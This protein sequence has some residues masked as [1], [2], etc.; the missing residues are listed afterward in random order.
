[1]SFTFDIPPRVCPSCGHDNPPL[2]P[3]CPCGQALNA[4]PL[5]PTQGIPSG[6]GQ[7]PRS[8]SSM[9]STAAAVPGATPVAAMGQLSFLEHPKGERRRRGPL[10]AAAVLAI[11]A[12]AVLGSALLFGGPAARPAAIGGSASPS[13]PAATSPA[14][15]ESPGTPAG[16]P[17]PAASGPLDT[18]LSSARLDGGTWAVTFTVTASTLEAVQD[19][20]RLRRVYDA[21]YAC[22]RPPCDVKARAS[23]PDSPAKGSLALTFA[24]AAGAYTATE[25]AGSERCVLTSGRPLAGGYTVQVTTSLQVAASRQV[26][27]HWTAMNLEGSQQRTAEP[28]AAGKA[29]GCAAWHVELAA[30]GVRGDAGTVRIMP[31]VNWSGY[32]V[33]RHGASFTNVE[34]TWI[35]PAVSC[36]SVHRQMASFWVGIDGVKSG[37]L[38]QVGTS[39]ECNALRQDMYY[40]WWEMLP[41]PMVRIPMLIRPGDTMHARVAWSHGRFTLSVTNVTL[42]DTFSIVRSNP[43]AKRATAEWVAE[44]TARC[45]ARACEISALPDFDSV[46]FTDCHATAGGQT[47]DVGDGVWTRTLDVMVRQRHRTTLKAL[48]SAIDAASDGFTVNWLGVGP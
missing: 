36:Q 34:G 19:G 30:R 24:F 7:A 33:E 48:P 15:G 8:E 1:M 46:R 5:V 11:G 44:A 2:A 43:L 16:S 37:A 12:A 9:S 35:Q 18:S 26:G 22:G 10:V 14:P 23:N 4:P 45:N 38:E 42:D 21:T 27:D 13:H 6:F 47:A 28:T 31:A 32:H 3:Q 25:P 29:H 20:D 41:A 17:A 40:A 39:S